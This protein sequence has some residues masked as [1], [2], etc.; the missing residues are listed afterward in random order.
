MSQRLLATRSDPVADDL[1]LQLLGQPVL[2]EEIEVGNHSMEIQV[3]GIDNLCL[4]CVRTLAK[5]CIG[6]GL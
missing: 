1:A 4:I 2:D 6:S 5:Y 3:A